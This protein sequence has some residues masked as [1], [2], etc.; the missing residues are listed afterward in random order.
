MKSKELLVVWCS[1]TGASEQIA[2]EIERGARTTPTGV[3]RLHA[4]QAQAADLLQGDALA[5]VTPEHLASMAGEMKTFFDRTYYSL[6]GRLE[7]KPYALIV[8]AGSDGAPTTMQVQRILT[9]WRL[10][11]VAPSTIIHMKAQTPAAILA[12]K[13]L[14]R[15]QKAQAFELGQALGF[16]LDAGVY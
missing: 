3:R 8:T 16:G 12:P 15:E 5:I 2:R 14:T 4:S 7:G 1:T 11:E 9:G 10:R 6:L 13:L